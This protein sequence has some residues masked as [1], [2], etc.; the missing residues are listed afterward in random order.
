[1]IFMTSILGKWE[2]MD[3][4]DSDFHSFAPLRAGSGKYRLKATLN[5]LLAMTK[6]VKCVSW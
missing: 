5:V 4:E 1:M 2:L 3:S 6:A